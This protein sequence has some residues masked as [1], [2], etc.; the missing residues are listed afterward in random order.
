MSASDKGLLWLNGKFRYF[1]LY[2]KMKAHKGVERYRVLIGEK[3]LVINA[4][5]IKRFPVKG[6][7][8]G[9]IK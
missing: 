6:G 3:I 2:E 8:N 9:K 5:Q 4:D 7:E 1:E